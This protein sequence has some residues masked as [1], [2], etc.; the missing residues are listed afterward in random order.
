MELILA[1]YLALFLGTLGFELGLMN[2]NS[3]DEDALPADSMAEDSAPLDDTPAESSVGTGMTGG[4]SGTTLPVPPLSFQTPEAA[5][6]AHR[7]ALL[8]EGGAAHPAQPAPDPAGRLHQPAG[9]HAPAQAGPDRDQ[10]HR[11]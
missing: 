5:A 2:R 11:H 9:A 7:V 10:R 3:E 1:P 4:S 8:V 6:S